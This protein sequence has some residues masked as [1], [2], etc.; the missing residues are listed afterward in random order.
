MSECQH[1]SQTP[2][3]HLQTAESTIADYAMMQMLATKVDKDYAELIDR[4]VSDWRAHAL[5][6]CNPLARS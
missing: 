5:P 4:L 6:E 2:E 1:C 3:Q